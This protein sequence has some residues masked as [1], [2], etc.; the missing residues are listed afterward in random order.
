[1]LLY[2]PS[3]AGLSSPVGGMDGAIPITR[4]EG[5]GGGRDA[6]EVAARVGTEGRVAPAGS[7]QVPVDARMVDPAVGR[8][9]C[10]STD[11]RTGW[12]PWRTRRGWGQ[13]CMRNVLSASRGEAVD[14]IE[15]ADAAPAATAVRSGVRRR[16]GRE[17]ETY[18]SV[19]GML[20]SWERK[21]VARDAAGPRRDGRGA[22]RRPW[23][24][25]DGFG[26][27]WRWAHVAARRADRDG[28]LG[29]RTSRRPAARG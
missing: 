1:M 27:G 10:V 2:A 11:T 25:A 21:T 28:S 29:R 8:D 7:D 24:A 3:A 16:S 5:A 15:P 18:T 17:G 6:P 13:E 12:R 23:T 4:A 22:G 9:A 26:L 14:G 19:L 20:Q